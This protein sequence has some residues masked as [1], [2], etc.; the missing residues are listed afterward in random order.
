M[1]ALAHVALICFPMLVLGLSLALPPR[2]AVLAAYVLGMLFLPEAR[3]Q[4]AG[5]PD[6]SKTVAITLS[7]F[8]CVAF[9][10]YGRLLGVRL[11]WFDLP[12][13]AWCITP[14]FSSLAN[15]LGLYDGLSSMLSQIF[16]W[17]LPYLMGRLYLTNAAAL[18][19][20]GLA[21]VLGA[22][23]Y[24]PLVLYEVR[25]SPQLHH[26]FYG[27]HQHSFA[28]HIRGDSFR[29]MVFL[30]H[31]LAV[32]MFLALASLI[33]FIL[34][35]SGAQRRV[36]GVP[37]LA[38]AVGLALTTM[39]ARSLGPTMLMVLAVGAY[40]AL[41]TPTG[42]VALLML[43]LAVPVYVVTRATGLATGQWLVEALEPVAPLDR[44]A[45]LALRLDSE[46]AML[47]RA[48]ERPLLGWAGWGRY[49]LDEE[50][51]EVQLL[52]SMW[53]ITFGRYGLIGLGAYIAL[54]LMPAWL[55]YQRYRPAMLRGAGSA[56][57]TG[58]AIALTLAV[59]FYLV[60]KMVNAMANPLIIMIAGGL[61]VCLAVQPTRRPVRQRSGPR[62]GV[63]PRPT[64]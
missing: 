35:H 55:L 64:P 47:G 19:E 15:G 2:R 23:L 24:T 21:V 6:Y 33:A 36:V 57:A 10:D 8:L 9:F 20:A 39:A 25:M 38:L 63:R 52:D 29:P 11:R 27:F 12:I 7:T 30:Q 49:R 26:I 43:I 42:R 41:R 45:S 59:T 50:G 34:W 54:L 62:A 32:S 48:W 60:D 1:T 4:F 14:V 44:Q 28:Q 16:G 46:N 58:P 18:R 37:M 51:R 31:A 13:L 40:F 3:Y 17:G 56:A 5:I 61:A 53:V 22:L